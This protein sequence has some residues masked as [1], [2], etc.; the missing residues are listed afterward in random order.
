MSTRVR[1]LY[2]VDCELHINSCDCQE[3]C[4]CCKYSTPLFIVKETQGK[5]V[6]HQV[7]KEKG[8]A[9]MVLYI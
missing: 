3:E 5:Y 8:E 4:T 6:G 7:D 2:T 9:E 1:S